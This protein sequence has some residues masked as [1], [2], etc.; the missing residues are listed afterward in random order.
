VCVCVCV[1]VSVCNETV[2]WG[3]LL[4][5]HILQCLKLL[6]HSQ[7]LV[8]KIYISSFLSVLLM[9]SVAEII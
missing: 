6:L 5:T 9:L 8:L 3:A 4:I 2:W 1:C 7:S